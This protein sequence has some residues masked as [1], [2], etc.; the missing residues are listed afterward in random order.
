MNSRKLTE[1]I[2]MVTTLECPPARRAIEYLNHVERHFPRISL[3]VDVM[4][5]IVVQDLRVYAERTGIDFDNE[6]LKH[7]G[8]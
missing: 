1:K 2:K 4:M 3:E 6:V 8:H 7:C 5:Q